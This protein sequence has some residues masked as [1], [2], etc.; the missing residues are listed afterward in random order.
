MAIHLVVIGRTRIL[1]PTNLPVTRQL[2][3]L[4]GVVQ[5]AVAGPSS[6]TR[7]ARRLACPVGVLAFAPAGPLV[8]PVG[9]GPESGVAGGRQHLGE[10]VGVPSA[11]RAPLDTHNPVLVPAHDSFEC[12]LS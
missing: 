5:N 2:A 8:P 7:S 1:D 10:R 4:I 12:A 11:H 9:A 3:W 6:T